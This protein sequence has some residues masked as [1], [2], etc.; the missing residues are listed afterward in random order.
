[1]KMKWIAAGAALVT[2]TAFGRPILQPE[3][4]DYRA[5]GG[6]FETAKLPVF[7]QDQRQCEIAASEARTGG[8]IAVWDGASSS[9]KGVYIA[10][11]DSD[12]GKALV[13][14][15]GLDVPARPQGYAIAAKDGCVAIVGHDP[16]G[17]LYGAVTYAQ[18]SVD[19]TCEN[20]VIRDWPDYIYRGAMTIG[21]GLFHL[22]NGDKDRSDGIKAGLDMLLRMK[23]NWVDDYFH[24]SQDSSD[25]VFAFWRKLTR[26]AEERG[27]YPD[28]NRFIGVYN[29]KDPPPGLKHFKDWPCVKTHKSWDDYYY[30]WSDDAAT[31]RAANRYAD[32]LENLGFDRA[33][34]DLHPVDGG[35]WQDPEEWSKRCAKCRARWNDH[36]RW[37]ASVNQ[38]NIY[39]RV[40][41]KRFPNATIFA[42]VY[43]YTFLALMKPEGERTAKWKESMPEY[44]QHVD[45]GLTDKTFSFCSWLYTADNLKEIRQLMPKR[46]F[47]ISLPY[48]ESAGIFTTFHRKMGSAWEEGVPNRISLRG[49]DSKPKWESVGL[50]AEYAWNVKAPGAEPYDGST[51]YDPLVDHTGPKTVID[52]HLHRIC[53]AY[54]GRELAPYLEKTM[55]SGVMPGYI[56]DPGY[57]IKYW[58]SIRKDP[59]F[60]PTVEKKTDIVNRAAPIVDS[61]RMMEGQVAAAGTCLAALREAEAH[62]DGLDRFKRKYFMRLRKA[63][64]YWL[65]AARAQYCVRSANEAV[66]GGD[67][68]KALELLAEG[69]RKTEADLD[70]AEA[71]FAR[72]RGEPASFEVMWKPE[73]SLDWKLDRAWA[74]QLIDRAEASARVVLQPRKIGKKVKLGVVGRKGEGIKGFFDGFENV[75][76]SLVPSLDLAELDKYDCI[77]VRN[78]AYEKDLYYNSIRSYVTRGG[79]GVWVEGYLCGHKRFDENTAFSEIVETAP[80]R[81]DNFTRKM[82]FADGRTGETMYVDYYALKPGARGEVVATSTDGR[83]LAVRG[84]AG[85]GKVFFMGTISLASVANTF[86]AEPRKLF[87]CSA[88][89]AKEAVEYFTGVRLVE[90]GLAG[91]DR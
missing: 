32:Y 12:G 48:P 80:E 55:S 51:F 78:D 18:M 16:V 43:P 24:V 41:R 35:S 38:Y 77:F 61:V 9:A 53:F 10:V 65:A 7:H 47:T 33:H 29:R 40:L 8:S 74:R 26:Y 91:A 44:W 46:P 79:G 83:P 86:A 64:P 25:K 17:A 5:T 89:L 42:A 50:F 21:R 58:N 62:L 49:S 73:P 30:C 70:D 88:E 56:R 6:S 11:A 81:V 82:K 68:A 13:K 84:T 20:A 22:G 57:F 59:L 34:I 63:A 52:S 19:G 23:L 54:W 37:K 31:E 67:N 4:K 27:I 15:F 28:A 45:R 2:M 76:A 71:T 66:A 60:D 85:L 3:V 75:E 14:A 39:T 69:R 36:E 1:M 90:K 72:L 87:G